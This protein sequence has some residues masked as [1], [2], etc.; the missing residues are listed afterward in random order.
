MT[1]AI[2]IN[3]RINTTLKTKLDTLARRKGL[4]TSDYIRQALE[5]QTLRTILEKDPI[6]DRLILEDMWKRICTIEGAVKIPKQDNPEF[7]KQLR[8]YA[9]AVQESIRNNDDL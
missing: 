8:E 5:D 3:I 4:T 2:Q 1:E 7:L 6:P 9:N